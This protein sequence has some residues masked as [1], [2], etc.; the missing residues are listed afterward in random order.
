MAGFGACSALNRLCM[1]KTMDTH[2]VL[3]FTSLCCVYSQ[4]SCARLHWMARFVFGA[5]QIYCSCMSSP[6]R[7]KLR[8]QLSSIQ[9]KTSSCVD[10]I[11]VSC[12]SSLCPQQRK[13]QCLCFLNI[14][15]DL[16]LAIPFQ[17]CDLTFARVL[18]SLEIKNTC[19]VLT[20]PCLQ[21]A[22]F[23]GL[24]HTFRQFRSS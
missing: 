12:A 17:R 10:L 23:H 24:A 8:A 19:A 11:T 3:H 18:L 2:V 1:P 16:R 5:A 15:F 13:L 21:S 20:T 7:V 14:V 4:R 6:R 9:R 22:V